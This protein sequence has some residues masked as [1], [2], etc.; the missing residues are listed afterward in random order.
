MMP[1]PD[2]DK[3]QVTRER[4]IINKEKVKALV[5][6]FKDDEGSFFN[7]SDSFFEGLQDEVIR[8][9]VRA[10]ERAK[11]EKKKTLYSRHA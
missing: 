5:S 7:I 3:P 2:A 9:I 10:T 1:V 4:M 8:I 11:E 6:E